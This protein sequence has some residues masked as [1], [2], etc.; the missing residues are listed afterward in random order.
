MNAWKDVQYCLIIRNLQIKITKI[1]ST[2]MGKLTHTGPINCGREYEASESFTHF[3]YNMYVEW[4]NHFQKFSSFH[5]AQAS[6]ELLGSNHPLPWPPKC[7]GLQTVP[8]YLALSLDKTR[9]GWLLPCLDMVLMWFLKPFGILV[10]WAERWGQPSGPVGVPWG[11]AL[12]SK[13]LKSDFI[14]RRC[15]SF[16]T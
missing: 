2:K 8:Q 12:V 9:N 14:F 11:W 1:L 3:S 6:L 5:V 4:H 7:L 15:S 13:N 10:G 16:M